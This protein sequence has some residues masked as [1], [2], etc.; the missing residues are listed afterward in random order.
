L[1]K[2]DAE[3]KETSARQEAVY[4][5]SAE[6]LMVD[7]NMLRLEF[8]IICVFYALV[9]FGKSFNSATPW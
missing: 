2:K 9:Y 3:K 8:V 7:Q 1:Y 4:R 6:S 5:L